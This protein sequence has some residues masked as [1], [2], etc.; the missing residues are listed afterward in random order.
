MTNNSAYPSCWFKVFE[1]ET[2]RKIVVHFHEKAKLNNCKFNFNLRVI[3]LVT[4]FFCL[5]PNI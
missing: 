2:R 1:P 3:S 5:A 4:C